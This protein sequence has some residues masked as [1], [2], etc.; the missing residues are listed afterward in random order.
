MFR[1]FIFKTRQNGSALKENDIIIRQRGMEK[2]KTE[3]AAHLVKN[4]SRIVALTG[5]GISTAAGIPDFR[6]KNGIYTTKKYPPDVFDIDRFDRDP[7]AF[8]GFAKDFIEFGEKL[9]P[10]F[11]HRWLAGLEAA[12]KLGCVITQNIDGM[13][14][15]AG[16]KN[17]I[18]LHGGFD[19]S[20]CRNCSAEYGFAELKNKIR[21]EKIPKCVRCGGVIKPDIVF[22]GEPVKR[23]REAEQI[24][25]DS[26]L[27]FVIG[28]SLTVYPAAALPDAAGGKVVIVSRGTDDAGNAYAGTFDCDIDGFFRGLD[29]TMS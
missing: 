15:R 3:D 8:Y 16:T 14:Q 21:E 19:K 26:D 5:A 29:R 9:E 20:Y 23:V 25:R 18:E 24:V 13:H 2:M 7:S 27:L 10:T 11:T 6:G 28:T 1:D 22:F 17:I 4:S 12:G